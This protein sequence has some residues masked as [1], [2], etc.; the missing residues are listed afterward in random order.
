MQ[1][2]TFKLTG[3]SP[4]IQH[5][6][7]LAN[8]L[9]KYPKF[10]KPLTGKRQKT[11]ADLIEISRVEWEGGIYFGS[12]SNGLDGRVV[13]P[14]R[15]LDACFFAGA[16]K[17]KNGEKWRTGV[18]FDADEYALDYKGPK[19]NAKGTKEIPNP[20]LDKHFEGHKY[21][22]MVRVGTAQVLRTRAIFYDW[23]VEASLLY[24]ENIVDTRT[25]GQIAEDAGYLVGLCDR[26]PGSKGGGSFGRFIVEIV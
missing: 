12:E 1:K 25:L 16:K 20:G 3:Q 22:V 17:K 4:L 15:C 19:I 7:Q 10:M 2:I 24:D 13:L 21:Q 23:S 6:I 14:G 18:F 9:N 5:N 26:R 8:P 11:D